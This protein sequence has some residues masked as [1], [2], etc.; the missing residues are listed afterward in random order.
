[1]RIRCIAG[2]WAAVALCLLPALLRAAEPVNQLSPKEKAAGWQLLFDGTTNGWH[3]YKKHTFPAKGWEIQDGWLH[4]LAQKGGDLL[5]DG[6]FEQFD[7][8]W[9]WKI[10]SAGNSGVKYFVPETRASAIGHEYQMIDDERE[11][12]AVRGNGT[13]VTASFY[14]VLKPTVKP[15]V[16]PCGEVNHSR[17]LARGNHVEHWLNG[18]KVLEFDLDSEAVKQAVAASKFKNVPDFTAPSKTP[19]L[20][21]DHNS[22]VWFQNIKIRDLSA[23]R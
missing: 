9:D 7:L 23:K 20:L 21:Q 16:K 8:Q 6:Q 19:I 11:P 15:P 4:G 10:A 18:T 14:D 13:H 22:Q 5:S 12:D 3:S 2:L 17:I 1:M